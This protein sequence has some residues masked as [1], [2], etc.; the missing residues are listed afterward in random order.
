V[1]EV[2]RHLGMAIEIR[3]IVKMKFNNERTLKIRKIIVRLAEVV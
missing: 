2:F 1:N 3:K